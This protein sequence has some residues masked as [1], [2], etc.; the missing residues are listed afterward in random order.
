[1]FD[2]IKELQEKLHKIDEDLT[3]IDAVKSSIRNKIVISLASLLFVSIAANCYFIPKTL[4]YKKEA[5]K[6]QDY[7]INSDSAY[8]ELEN[9]YKDLA[10]QMRLLELKTKQVYNPETKQYEDK[11]I[12]FKNIPN[13]YIPP[14]REEPYIPYQSPQSTTVYIESEKTSNL[15]PVRDFAAEQ[16]ERDYKRLKYDVEQIKTDKMLNDIFRPHSEHY[17][18]WSY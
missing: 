6:Y 10:S 11:K 15:P 2:Y 18:S 5:A 12:S 9:K 16:R 3:I 13:I 17:H 1:M 8:D 14:C 7:W 4:E